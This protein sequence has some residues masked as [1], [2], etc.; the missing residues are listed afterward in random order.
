[1]RYLAT[2]LLSI[3]VSCTPAFAQANSDP[4]NNTG[5][6]LRVDGKTYKTLRQA[7][8]ACS[9]PGCTIDMNGNCSPD[10][11][12]LGSFDPGNLFVTIVLG[13]CQYTAKGFTL[14]THFHL[15][16]QNGTGIT[17]A[18]P[19]I[20]LFSLPQNCSGADKPP[21]Q[22]DVVA[23][24][25]T[26]SHL[27][28]IPA[29]G[30]STD[31]ISMVAA[32]SG[33]LW[34]SSFDHLTIKAGFGRNA[35]RFDS[36]SVGE[37]PA[38]DQFISIRDV[39]CYRV[40]NGP[41]VLVLMGPA[42]GQFSIDTAE[43][44]GPPGGVEPGENNYNIVI[45]D[46]GV[47]K[48]MPYS[49]EMRNVTVQGASGAGSTAIY[50]NGATGVLCEGC[51][52]EFV[53]GLIKEVVGSGGHGNWAI[54]IKDSYLAGVGLSHGSGFISSTDASSSLDFQDNAVFGVPDAW[55][56][57]SSVKFV[58]GIGNS[59][60]ANGTWQPVSVLPAHKISGTEK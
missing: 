6:S 41:P 49:I 15:M 52:F 28:L 46:G 13:T 57:G 9:P 30:S 56:T 35:M 54:A 20:P 31:A 23:Q 45:S 29:K 18:S 59:N 26:I 24:D 27:Y 48:W 60:F 50:V 5:S 32:P 37:P 42:T 53:N 33:G 58:Y 10:A 11:L 8:A 7:F 39:F 3:S 4:A 1:M 19:D 40:P 22:N 38:A 34:Y 25:V 14:R 12:S 17:Q 47:K 21:C 55:F 36:T 2:L 51:H 44:D 16:G 43:F